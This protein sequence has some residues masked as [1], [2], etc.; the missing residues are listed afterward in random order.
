MEGESNWDMQVQYNLYETNQFLEIL[1]TFKRQSCSASIHFTCRW[2][3]LGY[4]IT[5][6]SKQFLQYQECNT[7]YW[8]KWIHIQH[9]L[10]EE[11]IR[12]CWKRLNIQHKKWIRWTP[13]LANSKEEAQLRCQGLVCPREHVRNWKLLSK[14]WYEKFKPQDKCMHIF[15]CTYVCAYVC[16]WVSAT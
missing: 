10:T 8:C 12:Y 11:S 5:F 16:L 13:H 14:Y 4:I 15:V 3:K 6:Q 9:H 7:F 1:I 2:Q